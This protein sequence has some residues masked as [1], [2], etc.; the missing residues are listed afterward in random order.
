MDRSLLVLSALWLGACVP[1]QPAVEVPVKAETEPDLTLPQAPPEVL[2]ER[3]PPDD[4]ADQQPVE[5]QEE[6]LDPVTPPPETLPE[7]P[8][9]VPA[10]N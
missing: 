10:G 1:K 7:G 3:A 2:D 4:P 8:A 9:R 6:A 5:E